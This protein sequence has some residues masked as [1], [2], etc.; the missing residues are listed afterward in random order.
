[1]WLRSITREVQDPIFVFPNEVHLKA[2]T[3]VDGSFIFQVFSGQSFHKNSPLYWHATIHLLG[4]S[5]CMQNLSAAWWMIM[6]PLSDS[7]HHVL[8]GVLDCPDVLIP[9]ALP[10]LSSPLFSLFSPQKRDLLGEKKSDIPK[11]ILWLPISFGIDEWSQAPCSSPTG[12]CPLHL[13]N[14]KHAV[15][16][17]F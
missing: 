14:A 7:H 16:T 3:L 2:C 17:A 10:R 13:L 9:S 1:M 11:I 8:S 4:K 5:C 12:L 6:P 15:Y